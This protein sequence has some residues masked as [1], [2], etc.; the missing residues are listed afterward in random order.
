MSDVLS[1]IP[2]PVFVIKTDLQDFDCRAFTD[3]NL[4][5]SDVFIPYILMEFSMRK[6]SNREK[7]EEAVDVLLG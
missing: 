2:A 5:N 6:H 4:F 1:V 3:P 7:C